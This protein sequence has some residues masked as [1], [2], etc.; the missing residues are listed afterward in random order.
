MSE[1]NSTRFICLVI[2]ADARIKE[3]NV[4]SNE[5]EADEFAIERTSYSELDPELDDPDHWE[6]YDPPT[7]LVFEAE[8]TDVLDTGKY[9]RPVAVFQR[10]EKWICMKVDVKA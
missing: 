6:K 8:N 3:I 1:E 9:I 2:Q 7:V 10:G 5:A 4:Y